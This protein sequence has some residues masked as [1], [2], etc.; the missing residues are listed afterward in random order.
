ME[1]ASGSGSV[2][3][4]SAMKTKKQGARSNKDRH[5]KVNGRDRRVRLS[6]EC[7]ARIHQLTQ[8]LGHKT[9][10]QTI[11]W[12]LCQAESSIIAACS[13]LSSSAN[14]SKP[15]EAVAT[16]EDANLATNVADGERTEQPFPT[17][18]FDFDFNLDFDLDWSLL[19]D[20]DF[21]VN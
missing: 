12:L 2:E 20:L 8:E 7:A 9:N 14:S 10:G 3:G 16:G 11:E 15:P 13:G 19:S 6:I 17:F 5:A 18:D 21:F 1:K 4:S